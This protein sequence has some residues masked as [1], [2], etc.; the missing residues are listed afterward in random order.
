MKKTMAVFAVM[1]MVLSFG[2]VFAGDFQEAD[3]SKPYN[4]VTYFDLGAPARCDEAPATLSRE[5]DVPPSNGITV[6]E[7]SESGAKGSC[8]NKAEKEINASKPYNGV[9]VF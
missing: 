5:M 6:F 9:T 8:A 7:M 3:G 2:Q 1:A 4:G